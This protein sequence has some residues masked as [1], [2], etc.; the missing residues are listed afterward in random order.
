VYSTA[1]R[2]STHEEFEETTIV[3]DPFS[4]NVMFER[5][6]PVVVDSVEETETAATV[7]V[8]FLKVAVHVPDVQSAK[9]AV[10]VRAFATRGSR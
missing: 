10:M 8:P 3:N 7:V 1:N 5:L 2:K 6:D 4:G 9:I